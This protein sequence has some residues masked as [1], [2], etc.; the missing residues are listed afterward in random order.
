MFFLS[1][2]LVALCLEHCAEPLCLRKKFCNPPF[3]VFTRVLQSGQSTQPS[4]PTVRALQMISVVCNFYLRIRVLTVSFIL[5]CPGQRSSVDH[6]IGPSLPNVALFS[7][8]KVMSRDRSKKF[9]R[10]SR[11]ELTNRPYVPNSN[12]DTPLTPQG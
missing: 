7:T 11:P 5:R 10:P 3:P 4:S 2:L 6:F 12:S 8:K 9:L 1:R